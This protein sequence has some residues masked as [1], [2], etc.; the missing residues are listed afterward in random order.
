MASIA[1]SEYILQGVA[2]QILSLDPEDFNM[3]TLFLMQRYIHSPV[4]RP[5]IV[6]FIK[7]FR[8][9]LAADLEFTRRLRQGN[10]GHVYD[11]SW[12]Y[13]FGV[14]LTGLAFRKIFVNRLNSSEFLRQVRINT[15]TNAPLRYSGRVI[16]NPWVY[17]AA[18]GVGLSHLHYVMFEKSR[19][20]R[21]DPSPILRVVQAQIACQLS[22]ETLELI[23]K[24]EKLIP[25][26]EQLNAEKHP[27]RA[28]YN[29]IAGEAEHLV[30]DFEELENLDIADRKFQENLGLLPNVKDFQDLRRQLTES[31]NPA[32]G[33]CRQVPMAI[34]LKRL[35][36]LN[37]VI[38][39]IDSSE[40]TEGTPP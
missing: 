40:S 5:V 3:F 13:M 29:R 33:Q 12:V 4:E 15:A 25:S 17:S 11:R 38:P 36:E 39:A 21:L 23:E 2:T 37:A 6:D 20:R 9:S 31:P 8:P 34:L 7:T 14:L 24:V 27:L 10:L 1:G 16:G 26:D 35:S 32:D 18:G 30:K 19:N 28:T 22:F